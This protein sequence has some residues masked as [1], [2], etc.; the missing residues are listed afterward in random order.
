MSWGFALALALIICIILVIVYFVFF[1]DDDEAPA[2]EVKLPEIAKIV[3]R[4]DTTG[5]SA[6]VDDPNDW[7]TFQ[8]GEAKIWSGATKLKFSDFSKIYYE[9]TS[10]QH[11]YPVE[12]LLDDDVTSCIHTS[13]TDIAVQD[14]IA[15]LNTP[16]VIDKI[17]IHNRSNCCQQRLKG[18]MVILYKTDGTIFKKYVLDGTAEW[19]TINITT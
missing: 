11:N 18:T 16:K 4:K 2:P 9:G 15:V 14:L 5:Q 1:N 7:R 17:E 6:P 8:I 19:Q 3:F 10:G 12:W 13:G